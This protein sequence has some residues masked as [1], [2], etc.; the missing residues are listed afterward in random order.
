MC[1]HLHH[2]Q[3][4]VGWAFARG[5]DMPDACNIAVPYKYVDD[6]DENDCHD[7]VGDSREV[8]YDNYTTFI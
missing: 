2:I 7:Y 5:F 6:D 4:E 3:L 8:Y 1:L